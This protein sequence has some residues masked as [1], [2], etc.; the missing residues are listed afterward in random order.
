MKTGETGRVA[1]FAKGTRAYRD[2]LLSMGLTRG[3]VFT[4]TR[5]APLGDP[6]EINVRGFGLSLR[7]DEASAVTVEKE[8]ENE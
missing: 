4:V 2:K 3:T 1:G 8:T 7:R 5:V 6:V